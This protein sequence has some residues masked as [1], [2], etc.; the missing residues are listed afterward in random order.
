MPIVAAMSIKWG[1]LDFLCIFG[2]WRAFCRDRQWVSVFLSADL[3]SADFLF[4]MKGERM[5]GGS[6]MSRKRGASP[7]QLTPQQ[8]SQ[9][10]EMIRALAKEFVPDSPDCKAQEA[11]MRV[12]YQSLLL[13]DRLGKAV[14]ASYSDAELL[15]ALRET[16]ERLGRAPTQEET[17]FV[18]RVYLKSR[19]RNWPAVLRAAGM[20]QMPA[21]NLEMPDWSCMQLEKPELCTALEQVSLCQARM[22]YPPRKRDM[23][24]AKFL[25]TYFRTWENVIAAATALR[26]WQKGER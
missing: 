13:S 9:Y 23:E 15:D 20:R 5:K 2:T 24:Q 8:I 1:W 17:F 14:Y 21:A 6:V 12:Q 10:H 26:A 16:A 11:Q 3:L 18:Y 25:C 22:G 4:C 19:F 7:A